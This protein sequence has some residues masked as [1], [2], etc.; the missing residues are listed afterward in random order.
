MHAPLLV[1]GLDDKRYVTVGRK[2]K[3]ELENY[4]PNLLSSYSAR[5]V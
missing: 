1:F 2:L 4:A 5:I 3:V